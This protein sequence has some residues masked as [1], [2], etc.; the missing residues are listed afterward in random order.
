MTADEK[1]KINNDL[2][3][4]F[5]SL[6]A[7][8]KDFSR[9]KLSRQDLNVMFELILKATVIK[10]YEFCNA[11]IQ[12]RDN[13]FFM[14]PALRGI[15][16]EYI[17]E[18]FIFDKFSNDERN[19]MIMAWQHHGLLKSSIAQWE[20]FK[21]NKPSQRLYYDESF[22]KKL[23]SLESELKEILK[24]KF[25]NSNFK[26]PLPSVYYMAKETGTLE[27][28]NYLYHAT[29]TFVHFHPQ[30]LFRM[31]WGNAPNMSFSTKHFEHYYNYF[32]TYYAAQLF[33]S[34]CEWQGGNSFLPS[35]DNSVLKTIRYV[36]TE[37]SRA[38]E[39]V[40][41]EEMNIGAFSRNF[42]YKSPDMIGKTT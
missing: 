13:T 33:C 2:Q 35:F 29:S 8:F 20:Y 10:S 1:I 27:L 25:P 37:I 6:T 21:V 39:I 4:I 15:C 41:F 32:M 18:K 30:N 16:E 24:G 22:P 12:S 40:T 34:I 5:D 42:H 3:P 31:S 36:L 14:L 11:T 9:D 23:K 38:P 28:Y 17:T 19:F 7:Y 26:S